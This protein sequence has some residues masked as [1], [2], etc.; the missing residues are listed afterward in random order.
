MFVLTGQGCGA[1]YARPMATSA[2]W[3]RRCCTCSGSR[4]GRH[5]TGRWRRRPYRRRISPRIPSGRIRSGLRHQS[6][7]LDVGDREQ[8]SIEGRKKESVTRERR[9]N[10]RVSQLRRAARYAG[11]RSRRRTC[12]AKRNSTPISTRSRRLTL[13]RAVS[14]TCCRR[15]RGSVRAHLRRRIPH[16][17]HRG[18]RTAGG[19][20]VAGVLLRDREPGRGVTRA[21]MARAPGDGGGGDG[22]RQP[23]AHPSVPPSCGS[24]RDPAGIRR[25]E[26]HPRGRARA[27]G[28]LR[29]PAARER[30]ARHGGAHQGARLSRASVP[31]SPGSCRSAP[32]PTRCRGS[33]SSNGR[34]RRFL[35]QVCAGAVSR[36]PRC[37]RFT[38]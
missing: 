24:R 16:R 33:R 32:I 15:R 13:R 22:D 36:S 34:R 38:S 5:G 30:G 31:A 29:V 11:A 23:L 35:R 17:L 2:T 14:S 21:R 9:G 8:R 37:S 7:L 12:S 4:A 19:A 27:G 10:L 1:A 25:I 3:R 20:R 26:A 28:A 6:A 18:V